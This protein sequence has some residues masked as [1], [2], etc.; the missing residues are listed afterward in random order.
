MGVGG[1]GSVHLLTRQHVNRYPHSY[2][3]ISIQNVFGAGA[4][5]R[6]KKYSDVSRSTHLIFT[7][8]FTKVEK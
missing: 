6:T 5:G 2:L 7:Q 3:F 8:L 1:N 4:S